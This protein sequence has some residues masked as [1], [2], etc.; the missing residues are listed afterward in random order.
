MDYY[1]I[2]QGQPVQLVHGGP[3][4]II[5]TINSGGIC[6]TWY[7]APFQRHRT[8]YFNSQDLKIFESDENREKID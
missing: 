6:C 1:E 7:D 3:E 5:K 2:M 4:M 8:A